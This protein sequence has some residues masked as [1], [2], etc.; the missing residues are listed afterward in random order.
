MGELFNMDEVVKANTLN[1]QKEYVVD[2]LQ[3]NSHI[4]LGTNKINKISNT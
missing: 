2:L 1:R 4:K 3:K